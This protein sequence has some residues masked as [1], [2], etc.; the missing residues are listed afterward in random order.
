MPY[1]ATKNKSVTLDVKEVRDAAAKKGL[2]SFPMFEA[3][4][5]E[6]S[7]HPTIPKKVWNGTHVERNRAMEV[8]LFLGKSHYTELEPSLSPDVRFPEFLNWNKHSATPG[9]LLNAEYGI[10]PFHQRQQELDDL[11]TWCSA[12]EQISVRLYTGAGGM[13]K[14]RLAIEQCQRLS[15]NKKEMWK[16]GF[17]QTNENTNDRNRFD[18]LIS[19]K[20]PI[21]L[22][23]D[24]AETRRIDIVAF[25]R[26]A[27]RAKVKIRLMLLART[28]ADWW[29]I[30]KTENQGVGDLLMS[31]ATRWI[32]LSPMFKNQQAREDSWLKAADSF[33]KKL[34]RPLPLMPPDNIKDQHFESVLI[35]HMQALLDVECEKSGQSQ[36]SVLEV[37]LNRERRFWER[38]LAAKNLP[39]MY[40]QA[41]SLAMA[42]ITLVGGVKKKQDVENLWKDI[43]A[44]EDSKRYERMALTELLHEIYPSIPSNDEESMHYVAPLQPDLLG[45]YLLLK[46]LERDNDLASD[47][48]YQKNPRI[49]GIPE[50]RLREACM[51][52]KLNHESTVDCR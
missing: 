16:T 51:S 8:A 36:N 44:L 38:K 11:K 49:S 13:G 52:Y 26:T 1:R 40:H 46:E 25:L 45:E 29:N 33:A 21:F 34:G 10:V 28:A 4:L 43:P 3:A 9:A 35:L 27:L 22:V 14:T 18:W 19:G 17:L 32:S 48:V 31:S 39:Y 20:S 15:Q 12:E 37:I 6:Y 42:R 24:Y 47:F 41:I 30:L 5:L 7:N 23:I 50:Y 2:H